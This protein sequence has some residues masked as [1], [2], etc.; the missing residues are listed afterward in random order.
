MTIQPSD[1]CKAGSPKQTRGGDAITSEG[2]AD[3]G[4]VWQV[5]WQRPAMDRRG[6]L[7]E[8]PFCAQEYERAKSIT[9]QDA[10]TL[11]VVISI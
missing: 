1:H 7:A 5:N 9:G 6:P 11:F 2:V 4:G 10:S 3:Q 8:N